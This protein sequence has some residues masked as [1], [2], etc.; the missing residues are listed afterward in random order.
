MRFI[1]SAILSITALILMPSQGSAQTGSM[2]D[3]DLL[4][5][6]DKDMSRFPFDM[7]EEDAREIKLEGVTYNEEESGVLIDKAGVRHDFYDGLYSKTISIDPLVST[8]PIKA[9]G[10]G[11]AR[12]QKQVLSAFRE[13]S[14]GKDMK[15]D[16]AYGSDNGKKTELSDHIRCDFVFDDNYDAL[17][18]FE[19][20]GKDQL[21][22]IYAQAWNPF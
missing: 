6:I 2:K 1:V 3:A 17:I 13:Y 7:K 16:Y 20:N 21:V 14:G 9:F 8:R 4:E 15:C 12:S 11:L 10:I 18:G 5:R 19:F 22:N